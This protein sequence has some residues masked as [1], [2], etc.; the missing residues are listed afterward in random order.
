MQSEAVH[1]LEPRPA[2]TNGNSEPSTEKA[3]RKSRRRKIWR[4]ATSA[5]LLIGVILLGWAIRSPCPV[6]VRLVRAE[7]GGSTK[8]QA[9]TVEFKRAKGSRVYFDDDPTVQYRFGNEWQTP[10]T[11]LPMNNA[12]LLNRA[13][14]QNVVLAVPRGACACRFHL[15]YREGYTRAYCRT[16]FYLEKHGLRA[17]FPVLSSLI[18]RSISGSMRPKEVMPEV[19]LPPEQNA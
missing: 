18:L 1:T 16:Y 17:K 2:P 5:G 9:I 6:E 8:F 7:A 4:I 14:Q 10:E 15:V 13:D 19:K 12:R 3:D 11:F